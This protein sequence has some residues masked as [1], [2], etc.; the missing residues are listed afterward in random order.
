MERG[1]HPFPRPL[2][3]GQDPQENDR[4]ASWISE[5]TW[6]LALGEPNNCT[7]PNTTR[8]YTQSPNSDPKLSI[9]TPG[10]PP[11]H[12]KYISRGVVWVAIVGR[13][14][15]VSVEDTTEVVPPCQI[16]ITT[17]HTRGP[18]SYHIIVGGTSQETIPGGESN[19]ISG[20]VSGRTIWNA[21]KGGYRGGG[22]GY[23]FR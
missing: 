2:V 6:L 5:N 13:L 22:A 19:P 23:P 3:G 11:P 12:S 7:I 1:G 18:R 16:A 21:Q 10:R 4:R 15:K 14:D 17:T 20:P 8:G 9:F